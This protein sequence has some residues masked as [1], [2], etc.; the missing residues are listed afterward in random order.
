[1]KTKSTNLNKS[2]R[3][4]GISPMKIQNNQGMKKSDLFENLNDSNHQSYHQLDVLLHNEEI[5][6]HKKNLLAFLEKC[7][8]F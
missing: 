7:P 5:Q 2:K 4:I 1:M 3:G 6:E 8:T